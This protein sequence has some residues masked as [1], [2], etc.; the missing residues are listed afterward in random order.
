MNAILIMPPKLMAVFSN[1][2]QMRRH[3]LSQ[4]IV[5]MVQQRDDRR[6]FVGLTSREFKVQRM[7][8]TVA[9]DVEFR[10]KS[11]ARTA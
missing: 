6:G 8:L 3:Y 11:P 2:E 7:S 4:P 9:D 1:R 10:G 5:G